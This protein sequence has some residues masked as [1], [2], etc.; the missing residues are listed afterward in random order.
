MAPLQR[1]DPL[2]VCAMLPWHELASRCCDFI[3][4]H[5]CVLCDARSNLGMCLCQP[6]YDELPRLAHACFYCALP[7]TEPNQIC[8][9]CLTHP[10]PFTCALAATQYIET[11]TWCITQFKF[12]AHL[13]LAPIFVKL[14]L[15][16]IQT[17]YTCASSLPQ[18]IIAVP[19]HHQRLRER[20]FNQAALVARL[21]AK[22]LELPWLADAIMRQHPTQPQTGLNA[23]ARQ[24][25][26]KH[27][28]ALVQ[29]LPFTHLAVVDDVLT[30]T[31]TVRALA[32]TLRRGGATRIDIWAVARAAP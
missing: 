5:H 24:A 26:V 27:A 13:A 19:L 7:L 16:K 3:F 15:E 32:H 30:T 4:P 29:P 10:P 21:L 6:C 31:H 14:L 12:H 23:Q 1:F 17:H 2:W 22:Q 8:G 18:A 20:G 9:Q 28:F 25:N 11:M